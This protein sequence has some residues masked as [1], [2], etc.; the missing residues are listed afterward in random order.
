MAEDTPEKRPRTVVAMVNDLQTGNPIAPEG[1]D[2]SSSAQTV[3]TS[4]LGG[5]GAERPLDIQRPFRPPSISP[6]LE[7]S[8]TGFPATL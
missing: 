1:D 3:A 5:A 2:R 4:V 7:R 6:P 8:G